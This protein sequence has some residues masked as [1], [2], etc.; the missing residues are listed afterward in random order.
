LAIL[1]ALL[2]WFEIGFLLDQRLL[3]VLTT[4]LHTP[5][6]SSPPRIGWKVAA[7]DDSTVIAV[8]AGAT[9]SDVALQ[10]QTATTETDVVPIAAV[11]CM[12]LDTLEPADCL[13]WRLRSVWWTERLRRSA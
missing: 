10:L 13:A 5:I 8:R 7:P 11:S 1:L 3:D 9:L 6:V 12:M 4:L 2:R